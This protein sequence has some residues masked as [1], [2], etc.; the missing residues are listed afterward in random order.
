[1]VLRPCCLQVFWKKGLALL[2][3]PGCTGWSLCRKALAD[4][5]WRELSGSKIVDSTSISF[6]FVVSKRDAEKAS[7]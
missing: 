5:L 7:R 4:G 2:C 1:M 6:Y 3:R